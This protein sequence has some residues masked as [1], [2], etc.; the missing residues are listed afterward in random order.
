MA[1]LKAAFCW[2][3]SCGGCEEAVIDLGEDLFSIAE[4]LDVVF[5]PLAMDFKLRDVERLGDGEIAVSL[6]NGGIRTSEHEHVARLLRKKSRYVVAFGTCA[7]IGGVPGLANFLL[8]DEI[9]EQI[10][11]RSPSVPKK[12]RNE[13]SALTRV[14]QGT[15]SLP[16]FSPSLRTLGQVIPVDF[17]IPGCAPPPEL[18]LEGI[19]RI[20]SAQPPERGAVLAPD[21]ALC[22]S[23]AR[24]AT[25]PV[26]ATIRDIKR[27]HE[28]LFDPERCF[29]DQGIICLG[30]ATR[31]G[32]GQRCINAN[33]PCRGCFGP[34]G[35]EVDQGARFLSGLA[36]IIDAGE[37]DMV[38]L[39]D[40]IVDPAGMFYYYSL[41]SSLLRGKR[42]ARGSTHRR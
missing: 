21:T 33:M 17:S 9:F 29:L 26:G 32:C 30:P 34:P 7:H 5:W 2:C 25:R 1:R 24:N 18:V 42:R 41:P 6:I 39:I 27:V 31:D 19:E 38:G 40:A 22:N 12:D 4:T 11:Q 15:L 14:A 8:R 20:L 23:C 3:A 28:V 10:Y 37:D 35:R 36:S 16:E 13:P